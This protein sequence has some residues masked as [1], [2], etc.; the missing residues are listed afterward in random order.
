MW[1]I[2]IM[3][4]C[5]VVFITI[6]LLTKDPIKCRKHTYNVHFM[7]IRYEENIKQSDAKLNVMNVAQRHLMKSTGTLW[8]WIL[9][10]CTN[11]ISLSATKVN[12]HYKILL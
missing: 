10:E 4:E 1:F 2:W 7:Q 3:I 12:C 9:F 11:S 5:P 6:F 8:C